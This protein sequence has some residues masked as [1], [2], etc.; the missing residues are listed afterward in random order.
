MLS[1]I[2]YSLFT[3]YP[4]IVASIDSD[5]FSH[6]SQHVNAFCYELEEVLNIFLELS[7]MTHILEVFQGYNVA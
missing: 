3:F 7:I 4:N 6:S 5:A 2:L 1:S